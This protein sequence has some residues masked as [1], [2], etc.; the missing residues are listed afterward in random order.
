MTVFYGM[1]GDRVICFHINARRYLVPLNHH[2]A[3][4]NTL[5]RLEFIEN[6]KINSQCRTRA[7]ARSFAAPGA[8]VRAKN[9]L[10]KVFLNKIESKLIHPVQGVVAKGA[11]V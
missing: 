11:Y 1:K 9:D 7:R 10:I 5:H 3:A 4:S 2:G 8:E 6:G